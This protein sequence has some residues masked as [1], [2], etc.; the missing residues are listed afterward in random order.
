MF[1]WCQYT[2]TRLLV[3]LKPVSRVAW[4]SFCA[5]PHNE[6]AI[7]KLMGG[8]GDVAICSLCI[9]VGVSLPDKQGTGAPCSFC[10]AVK[11][12]GAY[13]RGRAAICRHCLTFCMD[14]LRDARKG[15][16]EWA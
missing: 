3:A 7:D 5:R 6:P 10:G 14:V 15:R 12:D 16:A 1:A 4:C 13:E 11:D 2:S 8:P 9:E